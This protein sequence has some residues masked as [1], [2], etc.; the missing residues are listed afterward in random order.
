MTLDQ[1][2]VLQTIVK[3]GSF[4]A[5]SQELHRAQSAVSYAM[6]T[7]EGELGFKIFSRDQYRP[8]L[9]PQG[10]AFLKKADDLILQFDELGETAELLKR[11]HEPIIRLAVSALW[12]LPNLVS[13][14]KEFSSRFPQTEIKIIHDVLSADEHLLEDHA[15]ISLGTIFNDKGLLITEELFTV[16]MVMVCSAKHPLAKLKKATTEDLKRY[17]QIVLSSTVKSSNRSGGVVNPA[18]TI[19]VQDLQTKKAFL[20]GGL[21][22]GR[23][24]DFAVKEEIK[25]KSLVTLGLKPIPLHAAIGRHASK[26]LGPCGKFIWDYFSRGQ[27]KK[28]K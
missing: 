27:G 28:L 19:S 21:G 16:N 26:E 4:R 8:T 13:A 14:L 22:Y 24:P 25:Q 5:A 17:P 23:M 20:E 18:N 12:P 10:R 3:S 2:Q 1:L 6:R 9:T 15:D 11:G 7:L